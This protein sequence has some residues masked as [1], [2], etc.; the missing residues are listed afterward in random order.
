MSTYWLVLCA[1][2]NVEHAGLRVNR[3]EDLIWA[4]T[5][6]ADAIAALVPLF[7][8]QS[9]WGTASLTVNSS[10]GA[11]DPRW[12]AEHRG[13]KLVPINEYGQRADR[14]PENV[15]CPTCFQAV[16]RC[17]LAP[18]HGGPHSPAVHT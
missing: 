10:D 1:D 16:T 11:L 17:T 9:T 6:H 7:E 14:C 13:H 18:G 12:F 4:I 15:R 8:E 3:R 5:R 2:C